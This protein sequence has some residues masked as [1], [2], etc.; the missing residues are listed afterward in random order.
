MQTH[1]PPSRHSMSTLDRKGNGRHGD[2]PN[3]IAHD[4]RRNNEDECLSEWV[5]RKIASG[6]GG[7]EET[8]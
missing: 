1:Q 6:E 4:D 5:D 3:E 2:R 7:S 8:R